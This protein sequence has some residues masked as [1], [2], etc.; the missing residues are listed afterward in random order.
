MT[1]IE[2]TMGTVV[3]VRDL[4]K[5]YRGRGAGGQPAEVKAVDGVSLT[6]GAGELVV[7]LG[8][9][10]CG[11][12]TLLRCVAGLDK[13]VAGDISINGRQVFSA[14]AG[15]FVPPE[16]RRIGMMFQSYALWPHMTVAQNVAYPIAS[17]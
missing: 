14:T 11:K 13:P 16:D 3:E 2:Q 15:V 1:G 12:T 5:H 8:P 6:V 10:G 4:S 17:R 7:L 9:S